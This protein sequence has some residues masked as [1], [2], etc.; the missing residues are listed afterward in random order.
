[1]HLFLLL[2]PAPLGG[3]ALANPSLVN[4]M[5]KIFKIV[6]NKLLRPIKIFGHLS[7]WECVCKDRATQP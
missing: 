5:V 7:V 2:T 1:M 4:M 6:A 3:S